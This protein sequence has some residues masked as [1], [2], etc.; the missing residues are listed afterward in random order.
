[1]INEYLGLKIFSSRT[2]VNF[3]SELDRYFSCKRDV[4]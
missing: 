2:C 4:R 1:M 3:N